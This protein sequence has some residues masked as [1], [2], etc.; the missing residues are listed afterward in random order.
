[1]YGKE[2]P[3]SSDII[4]RVGEVAKHK[5][6]S[7]ARVAIAWLLSKDG[8]SAPIVGTTSLENLYDIIASVKVTLTPNEIK[9]LE[10]PYKPQGVRGH[11]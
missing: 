2:S 9:Y 7:M 5:G 8:V 11:S 3:E 1:M 10:E 4:Q 6:I